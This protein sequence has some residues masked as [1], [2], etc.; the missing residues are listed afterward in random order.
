M[1]PT[2]KNKEIFIKSKLSTDKNWAIKALIRIFKENQTADE[3]TREVTSEDNG[4]GFTGTDA[5]FLSSLAKQF[6]N[7]GF[8]SDKQLDHVFKKIPKYW[9]QI[10]IFIGDEKINKLVEKA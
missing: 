7:K 1:K 5:E 10:M 6:I 2:I 9:R 3:Q 8:L 4:C